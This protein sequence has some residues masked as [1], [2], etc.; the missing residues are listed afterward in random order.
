MKYHQDQSWRHSRYVYALP[1]AADRPAAVYIHVPFCLHRCGYCDFTLL[2]GRDDLIERYLTAIGHELNQMS[3]SCDVDSLFIGGGT[4][5]YLSPRQLQR[6]LAIIRMYFS[7]RPGAEISVE[8]NPDGISEE[9]L[10][11]LA[12]AGVNRLSL[13]VQSFD[14]SVLQTLERNHTG[15]QARDVIHQAR[16]YVDNISIDLIFGVPGQTH[17]TW[18][19][20]LKTAASLPV[21]HISTY[22]LTYEKGTAFYRRRTAGTLSPVNSEDERRQYGLAMERLPESGFEQY[23]ISNFAR[24]NGRC[25]H[26][27]VY[28]A[29]Q[30]YF[31]FGPGAA[32]YVGG[33]RSSNSRNVVHWIE[34]WEKEIPLLQEIEQLSGEEKAREAIMLGLR[35]TAGISLKSFEQCFGYSPATLAPDAVQRNLDAGLLEFDNA[36]TSLRLTKEGRFL[37]DTVVADFL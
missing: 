22:G 18:E 35:R 32:R 7:L 21:R 4:P 6:L 26:N 30:E 11:L 10:E 19:E 20:S 1:N 28:W 25:R 15:Q 37:A 12:D 2:A 9:Q 8:A 29:A 31:A 33:I 13:G 17:E 23:E 34:S 5:T 24:T 3:E 14:Q 16:P 36:R 27:E